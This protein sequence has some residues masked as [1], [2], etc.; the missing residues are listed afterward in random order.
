MGGVSS[1]W[2]DMVISSN[3]NTE[4]V[5]GVPSCSPDI[6]IAIMR[7]AGGRSHVVGLTWRYPAMKNTEGGGVAGS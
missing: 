5:G 3:E 2:T 4:G 6:E 7:V 1:H